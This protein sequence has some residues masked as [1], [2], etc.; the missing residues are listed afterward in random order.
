MAKVIKY[1]NLWDFFFFFFFF[2]F[3][4]CRCSY[5]S[6]GMKQDKK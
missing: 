2:F 6:D 3:C 4:V 5:I 1:L